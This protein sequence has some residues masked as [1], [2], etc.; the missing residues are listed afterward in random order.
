MKLIKTA[1]GVINPNVG[2]MISNVDQML[3]Q[4]VQM[5]EQHVT[6]GAFGEACIAGYPMEDWVLR[7]DF[8][9]AQWKGLERFAQETAKLRTYFVVGLAVSYGRDI[10]NCA[11][12]V[13]GGTIH[14][15]VPKERLPSYNVFDEGRTMT[16][17]RSGL[18]GEING[19]PFGD[20]VFDTPFGRLA[21]EVCEDLWSDNGPMDRRSAA[22]AEIVVNVSASPWRTGVHNTR[23]E[24][25]SSRAADNHVALIY[26]NLLGGQGS[27]VFDGGGFV[28][29]CGKMAYEA[30][31][32]TKGV[33]STVIDLST[34][35]H[36]R[37]SNTTWR[38]D[39]IEV[40]SDGVQVLPVS[41]DTHLGL[42]AFA[43]DYSQNV[44]SHRLSPFLP[45]V[46]SARRT[47]DEH[48][49]NLVEAMVLGG[50]DYFE[51][52]G[53]FK[54]LVVSLSGGRDSV[55]TLVLCWIIAQR[56]FAHLP[57]DERAAAV[58][59]F[60]WCYSF[61]T[62][63]N[64]DETQGVSRQ[65]AEDLGV[66]FIEQSIQDEY[67]REL[68]KLAEATPGFEISR[69]TRQN[70]QVRIRATRMWNIANTIG[71]MWL[72]TGNMTERAVGYTTVGGDLMGAYSLI[73]NLPKTVVIDMLRWLASEYGF[74]GISMVNETKSSAEL[75]DGQNDE[76]D[77]MPFP[78]L[79]SCLHLFAAEH[80]TPAEIYQILRVRFSDE[81]L[82]RMCRTYEEG[83]L[84]A[85]VK[86]F[87]HLFMISV[88]KWEQAPLGVHLG[89]LDLD[90]TRALRI[91]VV[92]SNEWIDLASF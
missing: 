43:E 74:R 73:G 68:E 15:L 92:H 52:T 40:S 51:K 39:H 55:L 18:S 81:D 47:I 3:E 50:N 86:R 20:I 24:M 60:V 65:L 69:I 87:V 71:A 35:A 90:R 70:V 11:A 78:V 14:G 17:G 32:W 25:I 56:R 76:D 22:G 34:I 4:A 80:K 62:D 59:D 30:P 57:E 19:V 27:L 42:L 48:Y 29:V 91:P 37:A 2:A 79:D 72:Q 49:Q 46:V 67:E 26:A 33:F 45:E 77:L 85:W 31:F 13:Q 64:S 36:K 12:L 84:A 23:R 83:M 75:E 28:N 61:P 53:A 10:Y 7:E 5:D 6:L 66:T 88:Y 8:Q 54:R 58:K 82:R 44:I 21:L 63:H 38:Q 9:D 16:A 41:G 89:A 1:I